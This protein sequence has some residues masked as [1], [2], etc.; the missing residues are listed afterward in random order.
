MAE[1][2]SAT[3]IEYQRYRRNKAR[4]CSLCRW[5]AVVLAAALAAAG[6]DNL[7]GL[8]V[9]MRLAVLLAF[10]AVN[11]GLIIRWR[12]ECRDA[13][14]TDREA[15]VALEKL[16]GVRDNSVINA[17][18][19]R[20]SGE[21]NQQ[22]LSSFVTVADT[23]CKKLKVPDWKAESS[24][25]RYVKTMLAI[26]VLT[27]VYLSLCWPYAVNALQRY[28]NPWGQLASLNF[29][30]FKVS[31]G[32]IVA[33][34]GDDLTITATAV[35]NGEPVNNLKILLTGGGT[36]LL[37]PM[38]E[39]NGQA[40][41]V[42]RAVRQSLRYA[43]RC[44]GDGSRE[45]TVNVTPKPTFKDIAV[46]VTA[47]AYTGLKTQRYDG[48]PT[49]LAVPLNSTLVLTA[50]L[51][52][53]CTGQFF[54]NGESLDQVRMAGLEAAKDGVLS[55]TLRDNA[56]RIF[57]DVWVCPVKVLI[58]RPPTVRFLNRDQNL[59]AGYGQ[60][61]ELFLQAEDDY[62]V[63]GVTVIATVDG[64]DKVIKD[65]KY[66]AKTIKQQRETV[67]LKI[68]RSLF[69]SGATVKITAKV[70]DR[71]NPAQTGVTDPPILLQVVDLAARVRE[72]VRG[73]ADGRLF[74]LLYRVLEMQQN[75]RNWLSGAVRNMR[76]W[77]YFRLADD[78]KNIVK[79]MA[80]S[81]EEAEKQLKNG[82][83]RKVFLLALKQLAT[84]DA[85]ELQQRCET[86][87]RAGE[88][89]NAREL[90]QIID[91]QTVFINRLQAL[92]AGIA[93]T[94]VEKEKER[95]ADAE[96]QNEKQMFEKLQQLKN[97]LDEFTK[98]QRKIVQQTEAIDPKKAEDWTEKEEKLLGDL[99]A[100][101]EEWGKLFKAAFNDLSKKQNQ[102]FSNSAMAEEV[103][104]LFEELQKAGAALEK[105]K[106]EIATLAEANAANFAQSAS[107]NLERWL[108]DNKDNIK[109]VSEENGKLADT[110]MSDLPAEIND[111]IGDLIE[112]EEDMGEDTQDT[113]NSFT[114]DTD[115]ALG[116][117]VADGTIDSMQA[118]GITGNVLPNNNEVGGRS[119][120]GRSGKSTGQYVQQDA[121]GKGEGRKT[122]TRL[123][124]SPY[125]K[126]TV[127]DKS[128]DPTGGSTGGG[129]QS[130]V[131]DEGLTGVTPDQDSDINQRLGGNQSELKQKA[132][133]LLRRL[134]DK[135][136]PS[137][138]V[139]E[140][141]RKIAAYEQVLKRGD[142]VEARR[143][144]TEI[145]DSMK[146]A[147]T[148]LEQTLKADYEK[149]SRQK[150]QD[151]RSR[152]QEQE[153]IPAGYEDTVG[154]YFK[155]LSEGGNE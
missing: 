57:R 135:G 46:Q 96:N 60:T 95:K 44:N 82:R 62:G 36:P 102:D 79:V 133:A 72:Q 29:A 98:E 71:H 74:E 52:E 127:D 130:G 91:Q 9:T 76:K 12:R 8:G 150:L 149:V 143:L 89:A 148:A 103:V 3:L 78:Q 35:R 121:V 10:I 34:E 114:W 111:I 17:V 40:V 84:K 139:Q 105:K 153:K 33:V 122:P 24:C 61:V 109:W 6:L 97:K 32:D 118:K 43:I 92:L 15:A 83:L 106:I 81:V 100:R 85:V 116:W 65:Y 107:V 27:V 123:T 2:L 49:S 112:K 155:S 151:F 113:S 41:Y 50:K 124:Q 77:E 146:N 134:N 4:C 67:P 53:G 69:P 129:K 19:F 99:A 119:G 39:R 86:L 14:I 87:S 75:T 66:D 152:H 142:G 144:K 42:I 128:K 136:L 45:F 137:G 108:A 51:P 88:N 55:A 7:C 94:K 125:E 54:W 64:A 23:A 38:E 101:E 59:E 73:T 147:K 31:P 30:Q 126:G 110:G 11:I 13:A 56:G 28:G 25:R 21:V 16:G 47:P 58:D 48:A 154:L 93:A 90:N 104:R 138:E 1:N 37:L 68:S 145:V 80:Q 140:A 26:L 18:C 63:A 141:L 131:G 5:L 70:V 115:D 20:E 120:E 117:G 22:L 132:Q